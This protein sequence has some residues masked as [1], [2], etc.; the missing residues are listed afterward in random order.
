MEDELQTLKKGSIHREGR[1]RLRLLLCLLG[2]LS[3]A[4]AMALVLVLYGP[5][6]NPTWWW[7]MG[8]VLIA[9]FAAPALAVPWVEWVI[10]GYTDEPGQS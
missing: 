7:V 9:A 6:Y 2:G 4:A 5:P 10:A 3:C 1:R 8:A